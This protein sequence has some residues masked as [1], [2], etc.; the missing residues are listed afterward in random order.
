MIGAVEQFLSATSYLL[1]GLTAWDLLRGFL[2]D[3]DR[4][5][6]DLLIVMGLLVGILLAGPSAGHAAARAWP[7]GVVVNTAFLSQ[8]Y[9]LFRLASRFKRIPAVWWWASTLGAG[10]VVVV[11]AIWPP[12]FSSWSFL[13]I[14]VFFTITLSYAAW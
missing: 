14:A 2:R 8:P 9:F 11:A 10:A 1:V 13:T 7:V 3:R 5:Q 4:Y 6:A 12:A